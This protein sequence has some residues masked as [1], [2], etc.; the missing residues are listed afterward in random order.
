MPGR[1]TPSDSSTLNTPPNSD[2]HAYHRRKLRSNVSFEVRNVRLNRTYRHEV[3]DAYLF[4]TIEQVQDI[5]EEWRR[6]Y[7]EPPSRRLGRSAAKA[8]PAQA[9]NGRKLQKSTVYLTGE[10]TDSGRST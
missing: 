7:N 9:N 6:E 2:P 1:S 4:K 8:V 3:L 5:T 10:L